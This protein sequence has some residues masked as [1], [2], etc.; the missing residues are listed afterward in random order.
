MP[1]ARAP[2]LCR[3]HLGAGATDATTS[4][5]AT[6]QGPQSGSKGCAWPRGLVLADEAAAAGEKEQP[7]E[8]E[9]QEEEEEE[10]EEEGGYEARAWEALQQEGAATGQAQGGSGGGGVGGGGAAAVSGKRAAAE[11]EGHEGASEELLHILHTCMA[12]I[13][14][15]PCACR[16]D[17]GAADGDEGAL[18]SGGGRSL[19]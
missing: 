10:E 18:P 13:R 14:T 4:Q 5:G 19:L 12:R 8:E 17:G 11:G 7:Q 6:S 9:E 1:Q 2:A 15:V 16:C 3:H